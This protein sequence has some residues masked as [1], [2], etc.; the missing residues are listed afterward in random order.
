M[1]RSPKTED[2]GVPLPLKKKQGEGNRRTNRKGR[3]ESLKRSKGIIRKT[4]AS[5][6]YQRRFLQPRP[7]F[8][9]FSNFSNYIFSVAPFQNLMIFQTA[10]FGHRAADC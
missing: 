8:Q 2:I 1:E 6:L 3:K 9:R 5:R 4:Y 10:F 7:H